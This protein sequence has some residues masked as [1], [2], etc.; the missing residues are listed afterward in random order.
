MRLPGLLSPE[1]W[2]REI[3]V[4]TVDLIALALAALA[5]VK[6][7]GFPLELG[8]TAAWFSAIGTIAAVTV[9]LW[10]AGMRPGDRATL[11]R[12]LKPSGSRL[13]GQVSNGVDPL[14]RFING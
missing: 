13:G 14:G 4:Y 12:G 5:L 1:G 3:I 11:P 7:Y 9:A 2:H 6:A 8:D 10:V